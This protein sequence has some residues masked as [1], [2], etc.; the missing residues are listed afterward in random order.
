MDDSSA[1]AAVAP[2]VIQKIRSGGHEGFLG[3]KL[4]VIFSGVDVTSMDNI[5][6]RHVYDVCRDVE[7]GYH[8]QPM[9]VSVHSVPH[10]LSGGLSTGTF[11]PSSGPCGRPCHD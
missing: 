9:F 2:D 10:G 1:F 8:L 7:F 11:F 5:T 6:A 4:T 3:G